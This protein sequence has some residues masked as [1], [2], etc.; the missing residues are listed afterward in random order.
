MLIR[1]QYYMIALEMI[2]PHTLTSGTNWFQKCKEL[3]IEEMF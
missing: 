3:I 2:D 1:D